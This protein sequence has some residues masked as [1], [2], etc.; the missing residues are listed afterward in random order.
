M[1]QKVNL[2][3]VTKE[4]LPRKAGFALLAAE[5]QSFLTTRHRHTTAEQIFQV[6]SVVPILLLLKGLCNEN[7]AIVMTRMNVDLTR[8]KF[9]FGTAALFLS[10][11]HQI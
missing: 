5:E 4:F 2:H 6:G 3:A 11:N 7:F 1:K 9:Q 8:I 10:T